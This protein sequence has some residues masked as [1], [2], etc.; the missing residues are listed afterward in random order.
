MTQFIQSLVFLFV[1]SL[2]SLLDAKAQSFR[3][4]LL[5]LKPVSL[6][7]KCLIG[8]MR[9]SSATNK[10]Q[11]CS[12]LNTWNEL[13]PVLSYT[14]DRVLISDGSGLVAASS[15]TSTTLEYLD[16]SSSL[17]SLLAGKQPT[18]DYATN[19][20][21]ALKAPIASPTFTGTVIGTF[22]GNLTGNVTGNLTGNV[23]GNLTGDV[24]GN[25][26]GDL[27]GDVLGNLT[28][29]AS[30]ATTLASNPT[31]CSA[32]QY[33]NAID[34]GGNLTCAQP[35]FSGLSGSA[36]VSQGGTGLT[37][38][39]TGDLLYATGS[40]VLGKLGIGTT[41][42]VLTVSGG[43][44]AWVSPSGNLFV[45]SKT[46]TY[47]ATTSD[48]VILASGS[49]FTI[50]LYAASGNSGKILRVKKTDS[51][52]TNIIT[53]DGNSSETIDGALTT[54][55]NTQYEEITLVCDG[56]NWYILER[57]I[58]SEWTA[59]TPTFAGLGTVGTINVLSRRV[60]DSLQVRASW[61]NGTVSGTTASMTLGY[62]GTSGNVT[63]DSTKVPVISKVGDGFRSPN[64]VSAVSVLG[65]G[66][67][68][69]IQFSLIA[70]ATVNPNVAQAG[71][72]I[73]GSSE[74]VYIDAIIPVSGW[75]N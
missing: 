5:R 18:G 27:V 35:A 64:T 11:I 2:L 37:S 22:S 42:Q 57:N 28:G 54:T 48:D 49:A 14:A 33:A 66:G 24:T 43:L 30:T 40:T 1:F 55:L 65:T 63:T 70:N 50:T 9:V 74:G 20:D 71:S 51:S 73:F 6:P 44:P 3:G 67:A 60:G 47:T 17:V 15:V 72:S 26:V 13:T 16:I 21:L 4:D 68:T 7:T 38:Y 52:L 75:K 69:V 8:D 31:D 41:N 53:I 61:V 19:T 32:N 34:S 58:P 12:A 23:T 39:T 59:Y 36:S 56:S 10:L 45:T 62:G 46:T 29:N 25:V